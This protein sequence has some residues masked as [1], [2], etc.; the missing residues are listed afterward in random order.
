MEKMSKLLKAENIYRI[1][2]TKLLKLLK[3]LG[4]D[5]SDNF[6]I[7]IMSYIWV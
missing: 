6:R 4:D 5:W 7:R 2:L 3:G 1:G